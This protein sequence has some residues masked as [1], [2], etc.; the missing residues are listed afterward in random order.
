MYVHPLAITQIDWP[1]FILKTKEHL[2]RDPSKVIDS[3]RL[4][5]ETPSTFIAALQGLRNNSNNSINDN[6]LKH[7]SASFILVIEK[8]LLDELNNKS[9]LHIYSIPID[10]Y[11]YYCIA[12][13][14]ID[15][16]LS[17]ISKV[18]TNN[19]STDLREL[20]NKIA[21]W[22]EKSTFKKLF[23]LNKTSLEDNTWIIN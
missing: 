9:D 22:F 6:S 15:T 11:E 10:R 1:T 23:D 3:L 13:G 8:D 14:S 5:T 16:W 7:V 2:G 20:F 4:K 18:C 21:E 17:T 12:T 19:S